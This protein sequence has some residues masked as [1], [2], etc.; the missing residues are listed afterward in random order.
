M[1][2]TNP[3]CSLCLGSTAYRQRFLR[4]PPQV[5]LICDSSSQNSRETFYLLDHWFIIKECN[6]GMDRWKRCTGQNMGGDIALPCSCQ[7]S[8]P[9]LPRVCQVTS[10]PN[11]I[12]WVFMEASLHRHDWLNSWI[13]VKSLI[14]GGWWFQ[15]PSHVRLLRPNGL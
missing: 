8:L 15:S 9:E 12:V 13:L 11:S 10:S 3:G 1:P 7:A 6:S 5:W 2:L 4:L 14:F